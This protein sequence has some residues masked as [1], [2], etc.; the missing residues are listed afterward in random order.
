M[1]KLRRIEDDEFLFTT[2]MAAMHPNI[3]VEEGITALLASFSTF[4]LV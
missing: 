4:L 1:H 2:N 3:N